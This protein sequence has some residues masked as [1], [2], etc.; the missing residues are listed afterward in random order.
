MMDINDTKI[1]HI[2]VTEIVIFKFS[3]CLDKNLKTDFHLQ[4]NI[5]QSILSNENFDWANTL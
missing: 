5:I 1:A 3:R 4:I 2:L